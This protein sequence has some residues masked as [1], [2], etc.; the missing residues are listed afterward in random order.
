MEPIEYNTIDKSILPIVVSEI[1]NEIFK[2]I[3][4][5]L[6]HK[7]CLGA[8]YDKLGYSLYL[9]YKSTGHKLYFKVMHQYIFSQI[10]RRLRII[11]TLSEGNDRN[12]VFGK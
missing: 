4:D 2:R 3:N 8:R 6:N 12:V 5:L 1:S 11:L 10:R 9:F 7:T